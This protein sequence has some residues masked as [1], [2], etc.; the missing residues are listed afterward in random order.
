MAAQSAAYGGV[1]IPRASCAWRLKHLGW[2][3]PETLAVI[4]TATMRQQI[5]AS[6]LPVLSPEWTITL[7]IYS[8]AAAQ[9][10]FAGNVGIGTSTPEYKLHVTGDVAAT[11]FVNI[12]TRTAKKD[13]E[14]IVF[15]LLTGKKKKTKKS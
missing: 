6:K 14:F 7:F 8:N 13:I 15:F 9:S 12:S 5:T 1:G 11:S 2:G 3:E 10:Y 4:S